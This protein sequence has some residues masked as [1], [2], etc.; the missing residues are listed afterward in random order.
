MIFEL[1]IGVKMLP[2]LYVLRNQ[3]DYDNDCLFDDFGLLHY[4]ERHTFSIG[5][6][7]RC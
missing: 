4:G 7:E 1:L 2:T 5:K 6:S 3:E